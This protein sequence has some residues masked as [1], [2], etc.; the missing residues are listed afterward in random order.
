[1]LV[2]YFRGRSI[3]RWWVNILKCKDLDADSGNKFVTNT[4]LNKYYDEY[5]EC[6]E[7]TEYT[8]Y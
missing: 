2:K 3:S 1:M 8:E 4:M 7:Y 6:T 5:T